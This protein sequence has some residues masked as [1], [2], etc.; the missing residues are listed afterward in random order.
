MKLFVNILLVTLML[1]FT[2]LADAQDNGE[3]VT[4][5]AVAA[6]A[7][8]LIEAAGDDDAIA[9]IIARET[10][11]GNI[12]GLATALA[13]AAKSVAQTNTAVAAAL[14]IQAI[15]VAEDASKEVQESVGEAASDV[16][17]VAKTNGVWLCWPRPGQ[18]VFLARVRTR[19]MNGPWLDSDIFVLGG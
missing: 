19:A 7:A 1:G 8:E 2:A 18:A 13:S 16:A 3:S 14:V 12:D 15:V 11:N 5:D 17:R 4:A 9:V 10:E 6:L